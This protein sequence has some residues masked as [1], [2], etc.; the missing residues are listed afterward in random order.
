[1]SLTEELLTVLK[2]LRLS[3]IRESLDLRTGQ[4]ADDNLGYGEFKHRRARAGVRGGSC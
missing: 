1:M 2:K 3:G 4:A